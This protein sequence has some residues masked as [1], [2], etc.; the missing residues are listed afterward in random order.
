ME[1]KWWREKG[2]GIGQQAVVGPNEIAD[3]V[4]SRKYKK[5]ML[6]MKKLQYLTID[7]VYGDVKNGQLRLT[8]KKKGESGAVTALIFIE[9]KLFSRH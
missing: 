4:K 1:C 9:P 2:E 6:L 8:D 5:Y 7:W 3:H